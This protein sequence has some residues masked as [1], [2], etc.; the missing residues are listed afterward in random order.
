M[1]LSKIPWLLIAL[2]SIHAGLIR[3][4]P[5]PAPEERYL[6]NYV[7]RRV[8]FAIGPFFI[9][10]QV[11]SSAI[12]LSEIIIILGLDLPLSEWLYATYNQTNPETISSIRLTSLFVA[13]C[14]LAASGAA[15]R[16]YCYRTLGRFFTFEL[17]LRPGHFLVTKGPYRFVRHPSYTGLFMLLL[18][19]HLCLFT[20]GSLVYESG[21]LHSRLGS[22]VS[23]V[24][25]VLTAGMCSGA[26]LRMRKEDQLL[27]T[28]FGQE[29]DSWARDVP[30]RLMPLVL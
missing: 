6:T 1:S 18:G 20:P 7:T 12:V 2:L 23:A 17:S 22:I 30:Y 8:H 13:G 15:L 14:V 16:Q 26:V 9:K 10:L 25:L 28:H 3:P 24:W 11:L 29:W 27:R 4:N 5:P 21:I 19:F